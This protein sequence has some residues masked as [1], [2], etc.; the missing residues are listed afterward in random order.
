MVKKNLLKKM[1]VFI[2]ST[3]IVLTS[4]KNIKASSP[5]DYGFIYDNNGYSVHSEYISRQFQNVYYDGTLIGQFQ[6]TVFRVRKTNTPGNVK[7]EV[8][9]VK[10]ITSPL[11]EYSSKYKDY[12]GGIADLCNA[13][14]SLLSSQKSTLCLPEPSFVNINYS[15]S[16]TISTG[17]GSSSITGSYLLGF[18]TS[19]M[20]DQYVINKKP[21]GGSFCLEYDYKPC[22]GNNRAEKA[23]NLSL[24]NAHTSYYMFGLQNNLT[25]TKKLDFKKNFITYEIGFRTYRWPDSK[26]NGDLVSYDKKTDR[27]YIYASRTYSYK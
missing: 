9:L 26:W 20:N 13:S 12:V 5:S 15:S 19:Y 21:F 8:L 4:S 3:S 17:I 23:R 10:I 25:E 14:L 7:D 2:L 18:S 22:N 11:S 6:I 1:C 24:I 16:N 27:S